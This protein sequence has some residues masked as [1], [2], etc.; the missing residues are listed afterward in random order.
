MTHGIL[1]LLEPLLL[2]LNSYIQQF[3]KGFGH[4]YFQFYSVSL[5]GKQMIMVNE[6]N[7]YSF[8]CFSKL[9]WCFAE[10]I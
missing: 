3:S 9:K 2:Y 8:C 7:S 10:G 4:I 1:R 6:Y 5:G